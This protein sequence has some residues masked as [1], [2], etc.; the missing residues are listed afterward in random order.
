MKTINVAIINNVSLQV[1]ADE[2]DQL[3]AVK[4]VCEILGV[5]FSAQRTKLKE[6]P[7]FSS[8]MVLSTTTGADGKMYEMACIPLRYFSSW[9][10]SINPNNVKGEK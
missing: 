6:H 4:P 10:F 2:R 9:L 7:L 8:V 3:V 5:D 1:V